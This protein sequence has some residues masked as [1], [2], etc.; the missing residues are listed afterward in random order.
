MGI[1]TISKRFWCRTL[2]GFDDRSL[3]RCLATIPGSQPALEGLQQ[4][5]DSRRRWFGILVLREQSEMQRF[6]NPIYPVCL[7][8]ERTRIRRQQHHGPVQSY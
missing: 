4:R 8:S 7:I 5:R 3:G 6:A 1:I 2:P